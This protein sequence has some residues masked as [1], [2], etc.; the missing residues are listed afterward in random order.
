MDGSTVIIAPL[1]FLHISQTGFQSTVGCHILLQGRIC[2]VHIAVPDLTASLPQEQGMFPGMKL[3]PV[4]EI[5][6]QVSSDNTVCRLVL[7]GIYSGVGNRQH[8]LLDWQV[9]DSPIHYLVY[10]LLKK[11]RE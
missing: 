4:L 6:D 11:V 3:Y 9:G 8:H 5:C 1:L 10:L 2:I 7:Q